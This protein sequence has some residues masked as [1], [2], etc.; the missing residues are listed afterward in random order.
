MVKVVAS[1][2]SKAPYNNM[3]KLCQD[4]IFMENLKQTDHGISKIGGLK[5]LGDLTFWTESHIY[6]GS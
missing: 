6:F 1:L 3:M 5:K 4:G 2:Y